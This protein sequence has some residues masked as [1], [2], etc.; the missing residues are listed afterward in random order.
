MQ[1]AITDR[2]DSTN[3]ITVAAAPEPGAG[4]FEQANVHFV[5]NLSQ[6]KNKT[7]VLSIDNAYAPFTISTAGKNHLHFINYNTE[8]GTQPIQ[9]AVKA[10]D[11]GL[12]GESVER[13]NA[14]DSLRE[15]L[16]GVD[17]RTEMITSTGSGGLFLADDGTYKTAGDTP[18]PVIYPVILTQI[19]MGDG[20]TYAFNDDFSIRLY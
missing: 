15:E 10:L 7:M 18:V 8:V 20:V 2:D 16:S 14:V 5:G 11:E 17:R 4:T 12:Y 1:M 9:D 6:F 19:P 13:E 3:R